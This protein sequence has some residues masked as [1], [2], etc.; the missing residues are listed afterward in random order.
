MARIDVL[1]KNGKRLSAEGCVGQVVQWRSLLGAGET[2]QIPTW[3]GTMRVD[4]RA[5]KGIACE[6]GDL[7]TG[8]ASAAMMAEPY[9]HYKNEGKT[10]QY[11]EM[12]KQ[13]EV[14]S[15][16]LGVIVWDISALPEGTYERIGKD[17]L[18]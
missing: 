12:S 13:F 16:R 6:T 2:V 8:E 5:V 4:G 3:N 9:T 14:A 7:D 11:S 18:I 17:S 10:Y 1:L 15:K